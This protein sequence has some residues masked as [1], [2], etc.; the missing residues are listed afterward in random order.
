MIMN[1]LKKSP[2]KVDLQKNIS[3]NAANILPTAAG[4]PMLSLTE[5]FTDIPHKMTCGQFSEKSF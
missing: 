2:K 1:S 5:I 4:L 3:Q